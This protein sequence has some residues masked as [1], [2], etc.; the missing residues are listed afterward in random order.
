MKAADLNDPLYYLENFDTLIGCV[1]NHHA[2]LLL[3][4]EREKIRLLASLSQP[5]RA[6]LARMVMRTSEHFR[7]D[8]LN[9]SELGAPVACCAA[10]LTAGQWLQH[11]PPLSLDQLFRLITLPELRTALAST[12]KQAGIPRSASKAAMRAALIAVFPNPQSPE[13]WGLPPKIEVLRLQD[14][15]L[16]DR[17]RLMFFGNLRQSWSDFV[18]VELGHQRYEP[19]PLSPQ[20]RA[21]DERADVDCYLRMHH[22]RERLDAG[23]HP[24]N[25]WP[26]IPPSSDN[27][28]L[29]GRRSRLLFELGK[30][31]E[32]AQ[33]R[34]LAL[35]AYDQSGHR[36]ARLRHLRL[37]ERH[38]AYQQA[39]QAAQAAVTEDT[40]R[41]GEERG[42]ERIIK[43]LAVKLGEPVAS[44]PARP[45]VPAFSMRLPAVPGQS[46]ERSASEALGVQHK[47]VAYVENTLIN[48]LF[49]LLCWE[50]LFAP[51]AGAFFHPFHVGP[52]D[53]YREDFVTRRADLFND[54][55]GL[56]G[57]EAYKTRILATWE[58]K[59]GTAC[60]FVV[61]PVLS[62]ELVDLA[63]ACIPAAHL[64]QLFQ[65]LLGNLRE[66]RSGLPDLIRFDPAHSDPNQ[67]YEMIEVKGP[68]DRL[69]DHQQQWLEF[70]V[71]RDIPV[72][73]CY[74]RWAPAP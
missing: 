16:F 51:I 56:L 47:P 38:K 42:L 57:T 60:A 62:R 45:S 63:L 73:V 7:I 1:A 59:Q 64:K 8:R 39:W 10:E 70:C 49:G 50:A 21:F 20:S 33:M 69:Q 35:Q 41:P 71:A 17:V 74:V 22:C 19:V 43:R 14:M 54:C 5:A 11:N 28:W 55:L 44:P 4:E 9:Y 15:A 32:R 18:L 6:L 61:W 29:E 36:E 53:L 26:D 66:H 24:A 52:A 58:Q 68:G 30:L 65:R 46:V 37:L 48:G 27:P 40:P 34:T 2:D 25:V 23:E 31:A 12:L 72:S 13:T 3:P 67:R